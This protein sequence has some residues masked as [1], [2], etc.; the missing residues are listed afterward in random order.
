MKLERRWR[1]QTERLTLHD[2]IWRYS[3]ARRSDDPGQGWKIHVS[4][5]LLT[6]SDIF[7]RALPVLRR[8]NALFKVPVDLALL[9][10]LNSGDSGFS[11]IGKFLTVYSR[12]DA[13]AV[14]IAR[15]LHAATRGFAAPK[16]PFD[17]LYR[18]NSLVYYRYGAYAGGRNGEPSYVL[19]AKGKRHRDRRAPRTAVPKWLEDPFRGKTRPVRRNATGPIGLDYLVFKA[20]AQRGK[21]G[22]FEALDLSAYPARLVVIKQGRRH[23][24]TDW[25]GEDGSARV[26]R[27][28]RTLRQLRIAGIPVPE[29]FRTFR[30][31][32]DRYL[33]LEKIPGRA[34]LPRPR[35]QPL[36][37]SWRAALRILDELGP[38]LSKLHAAGWV[39]R[40]CKPAHIFCYR[41]TLRLVDFEGACRVNQ[42]DLLP[43]GSPDYVPPLYQGKF[44]RRAGT[45]ED[46]YALGVIAFQFMSGEFPSPISRWRRSM[47]K[48]TGCPEFLRL[49][50]EGLLRC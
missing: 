2:G 44:S 25:I 28:G 3:H 50:I 46:D 8:H 41:G 22:V 13:D 10:H 27:E 6:A 42:E 7:D 12:S 43:W 11:Q 37:P 20:F 21:G 47:Y 40:D 26:K 48:R 16:I 24:D 38:Q 35:R 14:A 29:V 39:W 34:L 1:D 5:T 9:G 23:G 15:D 19:D 4:A 17:T 36:R 45:L 18:R 30:H 49:R 32:G 33:V 31:G